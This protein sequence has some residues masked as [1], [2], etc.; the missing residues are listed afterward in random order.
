M[1]GGIAD[2]QVGCGGKG[3]HR[4]FPLRQTF[5][6]SKPVAVTQGFANLGQGVEKILS[7]CHRFLSLQSFRGSVTQEAR[8]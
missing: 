8:T 1:G 3:L 6:Q 4:S 5:Q 2:G 7:V